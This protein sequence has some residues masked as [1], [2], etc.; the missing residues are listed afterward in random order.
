MAVIY[1]ADNPWDV[2]TL[3]P[4]F[5]PRTVVAPIV[6]WGTVAA[7]FHN[8]GTWHCY[9]YDRRFQSLLEHPERLFVTGCCA[10]VEPNVS[11]DD[12]EPRWSVLA[13][14]ARKRTVARAWQDGGLGVFADVNVAPDHRDLALLG[15]PRS[16]GAYA[17]RG[18]AARPGDLIDDH[19]FVRAHYD[20]LG[21]PL[22]LVVG[23]GATIREVCRSLPGA[24]FVSDGV[25]ERVAVRTKTE[26]GTHHG[27]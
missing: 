8:P 21:D 26:S 24:V 22:L 10:A 23:G 5:A 17:T 19:A 18:K 6:A 4:E 14:I 12:N 16:F 11:T 3:R 13:G 15:V 2:P 25:R 20:G 27:T 9:V 1:P 7:T